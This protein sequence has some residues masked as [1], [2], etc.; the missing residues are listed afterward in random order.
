VRR[1]QSIAQCP[2]QVDYPVATT[3]EPMLVLVDLRHSGANADDQDE[4]EMLR[5]VL[6]V[7]RIPRRYHQNPQKLDLNCRLPAATVVRSMGGRLRLPT[8][9]SLLTPAVD[10]GLPPPPLPSSCLA[11]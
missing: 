9:W 8:G 3:Y 2:F 11:V 7:Y 5:V 6:T 1:L 4:I 10:D